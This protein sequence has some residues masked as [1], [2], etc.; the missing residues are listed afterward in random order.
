MNSIPFREKTIEYNNRP[1]II[2]FLN[3]FW[4]YSICYMI[5]LTNN[6]PSSTAISAE[7]MALSQVSVFLLYSQT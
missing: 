3:F 6:Q 1:Y 5:S 2:E 7:S 4:T